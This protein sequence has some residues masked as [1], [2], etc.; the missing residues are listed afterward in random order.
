M[1]KP[2]AY[3]TGYF[4]Q[5]DYNYCEDTVK[6]KDNQMLEEIKNISPECYDK[7][8]PYM[9]GRQEDMFG[10]IQQARKA[11]RGEELAIN[12]LWAERQGDEWVDV[13]HPYAMLFSDKMKK[14]R[15]KENR[16][17]LHVGD[18]GVLLLLMHCLEA[19]SN[20]LINCR[21]GYRFTNREE[22]AEYLQMNKK[23]V[24]DSIGRLIRAGLIYIPPGTNHF[25]IDESVI[26][27][28]RITKEGYRIRHGLSKGIDHKVT[29]ENRDHDG[30][31]RHEAEILRRQRA[32]WGIPSVNK[33]EYPIRSKTEYSQE[34]ESTETEETKNTS[35]I[36][37]ACGTELEDDKPKF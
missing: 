21:T 29:K 9:E 5:L 25:A 3:F 22:I 2:V 30:M 16:G 11:R 36:D 13:F 8:K 27:C 10:F 19:H 12:Q 37:G 32:E 35:A 15:D 31:T 24:S 7:L 28:G 18:F 26:Q 20:V 4:S 14:Y 17:K 6:R 33:T 34:K 23:N 1:T